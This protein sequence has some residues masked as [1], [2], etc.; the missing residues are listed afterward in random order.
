MKNVLRIVVVA[1]LAMCLT[2]CSSKEEPEKVLVSENQIISANFE[3]RAKT[4]GYG[5]VRG[6][7]SY[8][9]YIFVK[10]DETIGHEDLVIRDDY[11]GLIYEVNLMPLSEE[12]KVMKYERGDQEVYD[13]Y[14]TENMY[15]QIFNEISS[16]TD[17]E[18]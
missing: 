3:T 7:D 13:I 2:A 12:C 4:N 8:L 14:L 18:G 1:M 17:G 11:D 9:T 10:E 16:Q 5:G 15:K 6:Y